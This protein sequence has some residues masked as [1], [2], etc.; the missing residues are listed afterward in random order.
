MPR[1]EGH[2]ITR[3]DE[4]QE[5]IGKSPSWL[6]RSGQTALLIFLLLLVLGS[7][8]FHYPDIIRARAVVLS[9]NPPAH[10]VARTTGRIDHLL[11]NDKDTVERGG[12]DRYFGECC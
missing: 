3:S 9:E 10:I 8:L 4:V 7:W 1:H 5:I 11:V 2:N 6:L 12:R